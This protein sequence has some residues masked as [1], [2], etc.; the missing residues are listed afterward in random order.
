MLENPKEKALKK[1]RKDLHSGLYPYLVLSILR[2]EG[3]L[4]DYASDGRLVP[5]GGCSTTS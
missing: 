2:R 1:L 4:H 5:S 3:K